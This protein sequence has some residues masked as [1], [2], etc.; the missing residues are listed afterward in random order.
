MQKTQESWT[1]SQRDI[2]SN[3]ENSLKVIIYILDYFE[4]IKQK[5]RNSKK[6]GKVGK[7]SR[8]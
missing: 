7:C 4:I 8:V 6:I 2:L 1:A 3:Y 5:I